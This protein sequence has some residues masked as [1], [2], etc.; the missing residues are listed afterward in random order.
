[1]LAGPGGVATDIPDW[2][3]CPVT[4]SDGLPGSVGP[5]LGL[6]E[7]GEVSPD[8]EGKIHVPYGLL[9]RL[10]AGQAGQLGLPP[11][12][13]VRLKIQG[14]GILTS[15]GFRF[16]QQL[17]KL[18]GTPIMGLQRN[19]VL[20]NMAGRQYL[21]LDPLY[22]LVEGM[23][24][25]N[26]TPPENIDD[27][28][29]RWAELNPLL[30]Q[31][32]LVENS[33]RSM[34]IVRAD[35]FTLDVDD[36]GDFSPQLLHHLN[37]THGEDDWEGPTGGESVLPTAPQR[38]F[39]RRFRAQSQA[40]Q[41]YTT[42]GNWFVVVP[43][44]LK[45]ALQV[46][47]EYQDAPYAEKRAFLANPTSFLKERLQDAMPEE[48]I[49]TFFEETPEFLS[50]RV[51]HLGIWEPKTNAYILAT[52][53]QWLPDDDTHFGVVINGSMYNVSPDDAPDVLEHLIKRQEQGKAVLEYKGQQ[54]PVNEEAVDVLSRL[55]KGRAAGKQEGEDA[56]EKKHSKPLVPVLIDNVEEV[57]FEA[58]TREIRG[59]PGGLPEILKTTSLYP[60]QQEG[61]KWLQEHWAT[62][63]SGA[64]LADDMGLGKTLQ[65][66]A[67]LGWVQEQMTHG[68]H[69]RKPLLIVAPTGL[70][71]NW[72]DEASMHLSSPGLGKLFKAFG[73]DL[74]RLKSMSHNQ[75]KTELQSS[76]W[77]L[78]TYETLR[79]KIRLFL[80]VEW[81]VVAF[82]E[83]QKI[84]NPASRLTEMSKS[85][86]ADFFLALTGTPVE[87][88]L[89]DLWSI[90]DVIAPGQLGS[91]R[92]FHRKYEKA[93]GEAAQ[94]AVSSLRDLLTVDPKPVRLLRR[95]KT[96]H[97]KG[98]P[99]KHEH[100][101]R[102]TMPPGQAAAYDAVIAPARGG[103]QDRGAILAILQGMR[104]VSLLPESIG[105]EGIT[106][107]TVKS[108]ARLSALIDILDQVHQKNEK[109]LVFLEF[110]AVQDALIPYLQQRYQMAKPPL[111]I[112]GSV[113]GHIRKKHVD[114]FQSRPRDQFDVMLLSPKAGGV[115]LTLTAANNVIHLSRWWN[116]AVEDQCTDRA[117]RI[118]QDR[119]VNVYYPI[120]VHPMLQESSFDINL[121]CLLE[122]KRALSRELL[123]PPV[124][125]K[126]DLDDLLKSSI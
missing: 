78:T 9:A 105:S 23:E 31:D 42:A 3:K 67:F 22:S 124:A 38:D 88:R 101:V 29:L 72:E 39:E 10:N 51:T 36:S 96:D 123:A 58:K 92:E 56:G 1:M 81:G 40:R 75:R 117:F 50:A 5:L 19:G 107:E 11:L 7:D 98:L 94:S 99:E 17:V 47:R 87:N 43:E 121:N 14:K 109:A 28:M 113:Q 53:Q 4:V 6:V 26:A 106:D 60:H 54:I 30:P 73:N 34:N 61:L 80:P 115:G 93:E 118:G 27:R 68:H 83:V 46:V 110:I 116:P 21:L 125:S 13:P 37:R 82:D 102:T 12:A 45:E 74:G 71:K 8:P 62:G 126:A 33:L 20:L 120:S 111:R 16:Q 119:P 48:Q 66:L 32:A 77:V 2:G 18:N 55:V 114:E 84:K 63:S 52:G 49:E 25:F 95:M 91:L 86:E 70:L 85:V 100:L 64:L 97:L 15:P 122:K 90:V 24:V 69:P 108:S 35:A 57:G 41:H 76:D 89:S 44:N 79:D 104:Q 112:S 59:E 103:A 65:T